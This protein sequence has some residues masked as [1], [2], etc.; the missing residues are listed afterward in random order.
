MLS[1]FLHRTGLSDQRRDPDLDWLTQLQ[2]AH[3]IHVPFENLDVFARHGV[4]T[5]VEQSP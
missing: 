5:N 4:S 3:M 1:N 2:A